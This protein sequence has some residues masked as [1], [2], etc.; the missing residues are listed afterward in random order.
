MFDEQ[1]RVIATHRGY[2]YY[3]RAPGEPAIRVKLGTATSALLARLRE[4]EGV[5]GSIWRE[6][7]AAQPAL[8]T[9]DASLQNQ[10]AGMAESERAPVVVRLL[11]TSATLGEV[12]GFQINSQFEDIVTGIGSREAIQALATHPQVQSVE[13]SR[14]AGSA[15]CAVSVP[16]IGASQIHIAPHSESGEKALIA[17]IDSGIDVLH[18]AFLDAAAKTRILAFWDQHDTRAPAGQS[19]IAAT[20]SPE[21]DALVR[22]LRV[23]YGAVYLADDIQRFIEGLPVPATFPSA[24]EMVHGTLVSSIAAGR[25]C[26]ANEERFA[27]GVAPAAFLIVVRYDLQNASVGYSKGHVDALRFIDQFAAKLGL[28]VVV[29]ISNG[30]NAGAHDGTS[31]VETECDIFTGNG[32]KPGRVIVKSAGNERRQGRHATPNVAKGNMKQLRWRSQPRPKRP[33]STVPEVFE[34]WF[35]HSNQYRFRVKSPGGVASPFIDGTHAE[36]N[37]YLNNDNQIYAFLTPYHGD[38]GDASLYLAIS[39]GKAAEVEEGEWVLEIAGLEVPKN[40]PVHA[41]VEWMPNRDVFFQD[42]INDEVT[43]TI[44]G[45][46]KHVISVGAIEVSDFMKS[47]ERSS[48]GPSRKGLEKPEIVAPGVA[49]YAAGADR[50]DLRSVQHES[51]TS[52]AAPHVTGAIALALSARVKAGNLPHHSFRI[53]SALLDTARHRSGNWNPET[54]YGELDAKAFF[55]NLQA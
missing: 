7:V 5:T 23:P 47:F 50:R 40:E 43:V 27:G 39:P 55:E 46:A 25:R 30:M 19:Q 36:L 42:Y 51:G 28:P 24:A 17:V 34:L 4:R 22:E 1:W 2:R 31:L 3:H 8:K 52:L 26:G 18:E 41:W 35:R 11:S 20:E 16:H 21:S 32:K 48:W 54:G 12:P 15:E 29:N 37:E 13:V 45:T 38:N 14:P 10:L 44:P 49:L 33:P 53:R 6:I 9:V